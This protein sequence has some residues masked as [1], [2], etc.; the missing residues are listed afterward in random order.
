MIVETPDSIFVSDIEHSRDVKAIVSRLKKKG[1]Q[2]YHRHRAVHHPWGIATL[3]EKTDSFQVTSIEIY[4]GSTYSTQSTK[5]DAEAAVSILSLA[6][7]A[8][9]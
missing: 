4:P 8:A 6:A 5:T 3:L 2:E 1:R 7:G 9:K